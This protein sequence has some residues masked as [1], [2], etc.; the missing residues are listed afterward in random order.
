M[1]AVGFRP[2]DWVASEIEFVRANQERM[3]A[4]EMADRLGRAREDVAVLRG[5]LGLPNVWGWDGDE[6][7]AARREGIA[8]RAW[9]ES[10]RY[11]QLATAATGSVAE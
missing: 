7:Q 11:R 4:L 6:Q 2:L 1:A 3:T 5:L 9:R 10:R 8:E